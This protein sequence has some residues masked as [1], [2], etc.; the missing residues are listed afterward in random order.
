M[1]LQQLLY[2]TQVIECKMNISQ[3]ARILHTSQS[4]VSRFLSM[5]EDELGSQIFVRKENR[6]VGLTVAGT[7]VAKIAK[8]MLQDAQQMQRIGRDLDA[9]KGGNL[10]I[11]TTHSH[12]RYTLPAIIEKFMLRFPKAHIRLLQGNL[13]EITR[14]TLDG[15]A[16]FLIS[17]APT[18]PLED[19]AL[20]PCRESHQIIIVQTGHPLLAMKNIT[21]KKLVEFP[22]IAY[23]QNF[24]MR[25]RLIET[26]QREQLTPNIVLSATDSEVIKAYIR[27]GIGIAILARTVFDEAQDVGLSAIDARDLFG[28]HT[29]YVGF[30]RNVYLSETL[31]YFVQLY[32]PNV[33]SETIESAV[34][35]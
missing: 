32:A 33:L 25:S 35:Q 20:I 9:N 21:L 3:S 8:R 11:A 30:R 19:L 10:T 23:D 28:T 2:L 14:W 12:A 17:T 7:E 6:L 15:T 26:F 24:S 16:D 31:L 27:T 29:I 5:L 13:G 18:E 22:I 34:N 1:K 4:G